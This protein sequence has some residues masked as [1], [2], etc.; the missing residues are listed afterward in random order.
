MTPEGSDLRVFLGN[1]ACIDPPQPDWPDKFGLSGSADPDN[2][3]HGPTGRS[4]S[5]TVTRLQIVARG[6][7]GVQL[8]WA[9]LEL[10]ECDDPGTLSIRGVAATRYGAKHFV[11]HPNPWGHGAGRAGVAARLITR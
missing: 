1:D 8:K 9:R 2:D 4:W 5:P 7:V 6:K 10:T 11:R 3:D